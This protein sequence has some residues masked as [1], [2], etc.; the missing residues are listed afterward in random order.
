LPREDGGWQEWAL[1]IGHG[2]RRMLLRYR[3]GAKMFSGTYLT[4]SAIFARMETLLRRFV[5]A[6]F[7]VS[8]AICAYRTIYCYAVGFT[9][10]EQAIC[11]RPGKRDP[12]YDPGKRE[13]RIDGERFP[14]T[15]AAG[16]AMFNFDEQFEKGLATIIRGLRPRD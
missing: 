3:D 11:P 8:E 15:L 12:R 14:L 1:Y 13:Q 6:G 10:E 7:S 2:V 4:D 16:E 9:I 5:D